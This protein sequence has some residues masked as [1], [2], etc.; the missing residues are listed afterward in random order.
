MSRRCSALLLLLGLAS[1]G[2]AQAPSPAA[3]TLSIGDYTI[4][5]LTAYMPVVDSVRAAASA[6]GG[7]AAGL[8]TWPTETYCA[9]PMSAAMQQVDPRVLLSRLQLAARCNVRLV[10]VPPRRMLTT[11]GRPKGE[12]SVE[13]AKQFTDRYAAVLPAD[14]I[15]KYRATILG[16][17]L[18]DDYT[19][20]H[21]W[22]GR[23]ISQAEIA[24]WAAY[25]RARLPGIPLGVRTTA[26]WVENYPPLARELDYTWAQYATRKGDAQAYFDRAAAIA[27]RLGLKVVMGMNV[28]NCY[29][30]GTSTPCTAA[31]LT[32]F[33]GLAVRHPGSCAFVSWRYEAATWARQD[34]RAAWDELLSVAR[35]REAADCR[36]T[37]DSA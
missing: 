28:E 15:Q 3:W 34:V 18:A 36:R 12:F 1:P 31:D 5:E 30:P 25:T 19:C 2:A 35:V 6:R 11:D 17:N 4:F 26:D 16:L 29:A 13:S 23:A 32:R 8:S 27:E 37:A 14:T 22:G 20:L 24:E 33:G 21:C 10:L 9:G 7:F